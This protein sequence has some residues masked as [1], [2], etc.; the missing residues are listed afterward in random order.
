[1][2]YLI[3]YGVGG[4]FNDTENYEVVNCQSQ[5]GAESKAREKAIETFDS[6]D[7]DGFGID[8]DPEEDEQ[9][10]LEERESWLDYS[11]EPYDKKKH[12]D[13]ELNK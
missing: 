7:I 3:Q 6:Y 13:I 12:K 4:G 8:A 5:A 2:K 11:A 1:M 10:F 9:E